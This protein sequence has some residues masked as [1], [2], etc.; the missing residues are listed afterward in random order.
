MPGVALFN[1]S[2]GLREAVWVIQATEYSVIGVHLIAKVMPNGARFMR[3]DYERDPVWTQIAITDHTDWW[4]Q[5]LRCVPPVEYNVIAGTSPDSRL[6]TGFWASGEPMAL[7]AHAAWSCL[8]NLTT[9]YLS[10]LYTLLLVPHKGA[11]PTREDKLR[12]EIMLHAVKSMTVGEARLLI[13]SRMKKAA[14]IF[15]TILEAG[16][17]EVALENYDEL[18]KSDMLSAVKKND[19][20]Q[21][22]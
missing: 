16:D 5:V 4:V 17:E 12:I 13:A 3:L 20:P 2:T 9:V 15:E 7:I 1:K 19:C 11:K 18:D 22:G 14:P 10:K 8:C 21:S 6:T